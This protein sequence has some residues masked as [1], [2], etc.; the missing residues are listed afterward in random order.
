M[1]QGRVRGWKGT[2]GTRCKKGAEVGGACGEE[3]EVGGACGEEAEVGGACGDEA[4]VGGACRLNWAGVVGRMVA[5]R[6]R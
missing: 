3:A 6:H 1:I 5:N 4:E 2:E